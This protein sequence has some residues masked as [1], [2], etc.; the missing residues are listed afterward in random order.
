MYF[1]YYIERLHSFCASPVV[2]RR[3]ADSGAPR[4]SD[5]QSLRS[6]DAKERFP[7]ERSLAAAASSGEGAILAAASASA[8]SCCSVAWRAYLRR[9]RRA[10]RS[11]CRV[12]SSAKISAYSASLTVLRKSAQK[13]PPLV[14]RRTPSAVIIPPLDS[15]SSVWD[16]SA[17]THSEPSVDRARPEDAPLGSPR[18]AATR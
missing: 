7:G 12:F 4:W 5:I 15:H 11:R 1:V 10:T 13:T 18:D 2:N 17:D 8:R 3:R 16:T 6:S 14:R 9:W